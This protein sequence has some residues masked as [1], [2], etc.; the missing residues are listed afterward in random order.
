MFVSDSL[1]NSAQ[2]NES[3]PITPNKKDIT[4][5]LYGIGW[6]PYWYAAL[7]EDHI[8]LPAT[9]SGL[10]EAQGIAYQTL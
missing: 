5:V 8:A 3:V 7:N 2:K 4:M 10:A 9:S 1:V 6:V